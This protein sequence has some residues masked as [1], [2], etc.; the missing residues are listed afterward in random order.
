[1]KA[2]AKAFSFAGVLCLLILISFPSN[3]ALSDVRGVNSLDLATVSSVPADTI[4]KCDFEYGWSG[5]WADNGVWE[6]GQDSVVIPHSGDSCAG[7]V[8]DS[9]YLL[10]MR[11]S[12]TEINET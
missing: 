8:L 10:Q 2:K 1:M 5:W 7:T 4:Y 6:V 12:S 9:P 3:S 11:F